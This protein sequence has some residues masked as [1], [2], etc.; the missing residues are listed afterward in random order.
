MVC[1]KGEECN[2][3]ANIKNN[4]ML[5]TQC[6]IIPTSPT[7][8]N[9]RPWHEKYGTDKKEPFRKSMSKVLTLKRGS[10]IFHPL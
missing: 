9:I 3:A 10:V 8:A 5:P 6:V 1:Y 4:F 2:N 7:E